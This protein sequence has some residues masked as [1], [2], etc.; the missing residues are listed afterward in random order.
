MD[1]RRPSRTL[2]DPMVRQVGFFAPGDPPEHTQ[3]GPP[4]ISSSSPPISDISPSGN[5]LSPV[6]IPPPRHLSDI[7]RFVVNFHQLPLSPLL[8]LSGESIPVGSYN[9]SEFASPTTDF[10][11]DGRSPGWTQRGANSGK[12][13][14]SSLPA[15][16]FDMS[17]KQKNFPA[18]SLTTVSML[19]RPHN[20]TGKQSLS[21]SGC[22]CL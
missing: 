20:L 3:S 18:S 12:I 5:S 8:R 13:A 4:G 2:I 21:S 16:G 14:A 1:P 19:T 7:S 9:P 22:D 17:V 11:E 6:M 10:A 15:G